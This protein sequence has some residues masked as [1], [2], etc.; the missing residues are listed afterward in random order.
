MKVAFS[1]LGCPDWSW[2][3]IL[4]TAAALGYEGIGIRGLGPHIHDVTQAEP[5][6]PE[7][8]EQTRAELHRRG[9]QVS[10]VD[11]SVAFHDPA[12]TQEML[13][14]GTAHAALA[15]Q[16]GARCIRVFGNVVPPGQTWQAV[17]RRVAD[18]LRELASRAAA[19]GVDVLLETH[20]DFVSGEDVR[21]IVELACH[22]GVGV[23]WDVHHTFRLAG[24]APADTFRAI[25][26]FVRA[27]H[28]KDSLG[29]RESHRYCALGAGDVPIRECLRLLSDAGYD[30]WITFE[31]EKRWHPEI[32]SPEVAF[33]Q[34]ITEIRR[35]L[36]SIGIG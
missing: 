10:C 27:T 34:F 17:S 11:T 7:Q 3:R 30:G 19:L 35:L 4:D 13:A 9:L 12:R 21:R 15:A 2:E 36:S 26:P 6:L 29:T 22:P 23:L 8:I 16:L 25:G 24:E 5:F 31:W 1:T 14:S 28:F 32:E 20:G 33:P 18:G